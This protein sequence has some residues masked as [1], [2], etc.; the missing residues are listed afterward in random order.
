MQRW[1][2]RVAV[3]AAL[4]LSVPMMAYA[5]WTWTPQTGRFVNIKK[6]PKE[7][8]E[9][10]IEYGRSLLMQGDLKR[11]WQETNKFTS[12]YSDS[13]MADQNQ[14][15][16]GEIR[17][18]EG[19]LVEAA[20]DFQQVV[21]KYP[22]ST[23]YDQ[24]IKKQYEIGDKLYERG[25]ARLHSW[26]RLS[27]KKPFKNAIEV[28]SMVINN[29]P[30]TDAAAEAQYK[31]GLCHHTRKEYHEAA[32]EY[33][34]VIEDYSTSTWVADAC[35]GLAACYC[36]SAHSSLY[37]QKPSEL[38]VDAIDDFKHRF[39]N[40]QRVAELDLKR[41]KMRDNIARQRLDTAEFYAKR[42]DF[43]AARI[44]YEL[45]AKEFGDTVVAEKAQKWLADNPIKEARPADKALRGN[46]Q[47]S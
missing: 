20:K 37:D 13:P 26:W 47:A 15:L 34:R 35:H 32:F 30:F 22:H 25:K 10:Q 46:Q 6:L 1:T 7:T 39:P 5:Q 43:P 4:A 12:V 31:V 19:K 17:L 42:R 24:V 21:A 33:R 28:Y 36:E 16:R 23:L 40:D 11:A 18:A 14:F 29:Q 3:V 9:L 44:Y 2:L 8:P 41:A 38:A 27:R 45:I